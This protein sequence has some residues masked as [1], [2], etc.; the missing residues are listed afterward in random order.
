LIRF[1]NTMFV[2]KLDPDIFKNENDKNYRLAV[3]LDKKK[4]ENFFTEEGFRIINV[5]QIFRNMHGKLKKSGKVYFFKLASTKDISERTYNEMVWNNEIN[6]VITKNDVDYFSVPKTIYS[7]YFED[8]FYYITEFFD[9]QAIATKNPINVGSLHKWL[10][11]IIETNLFFLNL[12]DHLSLPR[13]DSEYEG[14]VNFFLE[15]YN[16]DLKLLQNL[17][18]FSL[19]EVLSIEEILKESYKAALNHGD[20]VPWHMIDNV[21]N[22][23]LVD[24]EH[25]SCKLPKYF[26]IVYLYTRIY[27]ALELPDLAKKYINLIRTNIPSAEKEFFDLSIKPLVANRIISGFWHAKNESKTNMKYYFELKRDLLTNQLY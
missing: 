18:E 20:F 10:D 22:F 14:K 9:G 16:Q 27:T 3:A 5:C 23:I 19:N 2:D 6:K 17:K 1:L 25:G 24:G 7:G 26:D 13:D 21:V 11:K 15:F 8:K 4:I 12:K